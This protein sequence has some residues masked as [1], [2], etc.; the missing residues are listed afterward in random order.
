[1]LKCISGLDKEGQGGEDES[2]NY[3]YPGVTGVIRPCR[4]RL[5]NMLGILSSTS[6]GASRYRFPS[7]MLLCPNM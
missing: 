5:N 3:S 1:M 7:N 6:C 4:R 2:V